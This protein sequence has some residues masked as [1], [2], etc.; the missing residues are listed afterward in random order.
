MSSNF[1]WRKLLDTLASNTFILLMSGS[2]DGGDTKRHPQT[3]SMLIN[4]FPC[5]IEW[6]I[7]GC[8]GMLLDTPASN[9]SILLMLKSEGWK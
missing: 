7:E 1:H 5:E 8:T 6:G 2:Q 3:V 4:V 9:T